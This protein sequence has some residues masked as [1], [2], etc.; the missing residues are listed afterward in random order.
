MVNFIDIIDLLFLKK[1]ILWL[2]LG[3]KTQVSY[4]AKQKIFT[5]LLFTRLE[6][7]SRVLF[8][9]LLKDYEY[10]SGDLD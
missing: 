4:P 1:L 8:P 6:A 3:K 2:E 5:V 9:S 7:P 10:Y